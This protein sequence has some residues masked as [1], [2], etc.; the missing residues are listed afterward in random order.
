MKRFVK[1]TLLLLLF[2]PA[3]FAQQEEYGIASYYS[4][5]FHGKPTASG[6]LYDKTKLTGAHKTLPFGTI[7][8]VTR[9]D[10]KKSVQIRINDRGPFIS[11]RII[12]L[13]RAAAKKIDL[14][15]DGSARVKVEVIGNASKNGAVA[16]KDTPKSYEEPVNI[17]K[18]SPA[19][20]PKSKGKQTKA[21]PAAKKAAPKEAPVGKVT[22]IQ[23]G[24]LYQIELRKPQKQGYGV[25]VAAFS[26][27]EAMLRKVADLQASW[28][29]NILVSRVEGKNSQVQYKIILGTF[30]TEAAAREYKK[31]LKKNKKIDG[32][33]VDLSSF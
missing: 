21:K 27:E 1:T 13:S 22:G 33:V 23:S 31:N 5:L 24:D 16:A 2:C 8:K 4:D 28:F 14:I 25:Q 32:F 6:E 3:L 18:P 7:V 20:K 10:N 30:D 26:S 29:D 19:V 12:E 11:G 9:F 17:I 15:H